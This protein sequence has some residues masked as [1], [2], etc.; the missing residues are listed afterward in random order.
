M[1]DAVDSLAMLITSSASV[2]CIASRNPSLQRAFVQQIKMNKGRTAPQKCLERL[3]RLLPIAA[4]NLHI[5]S[6]KQF[7]KNCANSSEH[8]CIEMSIRSSGF[9]EERM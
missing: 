6:F 7:P 4:S 1:T 5:F 8:K 2:A 9:T 3:K